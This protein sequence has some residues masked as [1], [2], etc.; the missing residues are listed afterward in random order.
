MSA[1]PRISAEPDSNGTSAPHE[2]GS[3][4]RERLKLALLIGLVC[5]L[6][7]NA[8]GRLISTG[9]TYPARYLPFAILQHRTIH[10]DPV[11]AV[12]AQGRGDS[13]F[14]MVHGRNGHII[15]LYPV[16][17]PVLVTPLYIPSVVY[18]WL[19]EDGGQR[20]EHVA[21]IMEKISAS[22]LASL[23][24][25]LL[26]LLLRR[27]ADTTVALLLTVAYAFGT[28]TWVIGSQ[29]L[30]QHGMGALLV[31]ATLLFLTGRVSPARAIAAGVFCGLIAANRPPDA[32]LAAVLGVYG[33][34]W[35]GRRHVAWFVSACAL[36]LLLVTA[37]NFIA[38]GH[39]LGGYGLRGSAAFFSNPFLPGIAGLLVS[40]TRGLLIFSPFLIALALA[41]RHRPSRTDDRLLTLAMLAGV[42]LQI[43]V[44]AKSEWPGGFSWGPRYM[45]D[46][47]PFLVWMLVPVVSALRRAG[48]AIFVVLTAAAITISAIGAFCYEPSVDHPIYPADRGGRPDT[49]ALWQWKNAPFIASL[50]L[51][52]VPGD[53]TTRIRGAFDSIETSSGPTQRITI[54]ERVEAVGWALAGHET[55]AQVAIMVDGA[56]AFL[57]TSFVE[58]PD[59]RAAL[60]ESSPTGWRVFIDTSTLLPGTHTF[61]ALVWITLRGEP[62]LLAERTLVIEAESPAGANGAVPDDLRESAATAAQRI[63]AHQDPEGYWL[64]SYTSGTRFEDARPEMNTF[65]TALLIDLLDPLAERGG[66][67]ANLERART[68]L[69]A[70]IEPGGLVRY[71]GLPNGRGIGTLG[72]AIT[73]DTDD[74]AL[75][76]RLA[77]AADRREM[78][79]ALATIERFRTPEGLYRTWLAP[80]E[81]YQCLDPGADPNPTDITIQMHLM[82]LLLEERPAAGQALCEALRPVVDEDRVWAYYR[83]APLVP[84]LRQSEL[85]SAGCALAFPGSR[86]ESPVES[87]QIW[88][89]VGEMLSTGAT[90]DRRS[91]DVV[92]RRM[93]LRELAKDD[94]AL[95]R[96]NPPLLYHN[97][98]TATVSRYYWSEDVGYALWLRLHD[99]SGPGAGAVIRPPSSLSAE[100]AT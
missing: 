12:T 9:D 32:I 26:F 64:T 22:L 89:A 94:F 99:E 60:Q 87:Q 95:L 74:T 10:L 31:I 2:D 55:P 88:M 83:K 48:R 15:P 20:F 54:G 77:P 51:G 42:V 24:A 73:P 19:S 8:N 44:Y 16:L 38:A 37:Y 80:R 53:L 40:P 35:A 25:A 66:L 78:D 75:T 50:E 71:H 100:G 65:L 84:M 58:R 93:V 79:A 11:A 27:R 43:V 33:L 67:A 4:R 29:A 45:N 97:D 85:Q 90:R 3:A 47:L 76:W 5:M 72:C 68:H 36:P 59:V 6:I 41:W 70:Q 28:T 69:T 98:L 39:L 14:W 52:R 23:S 92:L 30:W 1:I 18:L 91:S 62:R 96:A 82:Q 46:L 61:S 49:H 34:Y 57:T 13:A 63:R 81:A 7:Y 17:V 86:L 56:R 21:R